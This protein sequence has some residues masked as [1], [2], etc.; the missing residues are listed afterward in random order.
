[1]SFFKLYKWF[2]KFLLFAYLAALGL[3]CSTWDLPFSLWQAVSLVAA[4]G[5]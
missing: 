5:I 4:C 1:M 3:S 2:F